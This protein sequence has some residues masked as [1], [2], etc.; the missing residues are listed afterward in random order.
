M[1]TLVALPPQPPQN[2]HTFENND[3]SNHKIV[4]DSMFLV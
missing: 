2:E 4:V 3:K 1:I